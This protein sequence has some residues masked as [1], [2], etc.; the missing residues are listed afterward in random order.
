MVN[1]FGIT[2]PIYWHPDEAGKALQLQQGQYNF[3]HPQLL[4][5]LASLSDAIVPGDSMRHQVLAGRTVSVAAASV[6][7]GTFAVIIARKFGSLWLGAS[8]AV[9]VAATPS[10]FI[11][12]H[13]FKEDAV[14]LMGIAVT[15]LAMQLVDEIP[16]RRRVVALGIALG[17]ACSA[18]YVGVAM[19]IPVAWLLLSRRVAGLDL[20]LCLLFAV[21]VFL[22]V[23]NPTIF[24]PSSLR[25]GFM[26]ELSHVTESHGG[27]AWGPLS[28]RTLLHFW[29]GV[30]IPIFIVLLAGLIVHFG[31]L[32]VFDAIILVSP[33]MWLA[34]AQMSAVSF[35]RYIMPAAALTSVAAVWAYGMTPPTRSRLKVLMLV[36]LLLGGVLMVRPIT[37]A[38]LA[39]VDNP[40]NRAV[41]WI[42]QN[43][44]SDSVI[45]TEFFSGLPTRER[46][47]TDSSVDLLPQKVVQRT[48][49]LSGEGSLDRLR[50]DGVTH[51]VVS[52]SHFDRFYDRYAAYSDLAL[53]QKKFYDEIFSTL[54]PIHEESKYSE[55]D[56]VLSSRVLVYDIR[57]PDNKLIARDAN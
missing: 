37:N 33:F 29:Q 53:T 32:R 31:K 56:I 36:G 5:R 30:S 52:S 47:E 22:A 44:S 54:T 16:S 8:V 23:N 26:S 18:K 48:F 43:L 11:N 38:A 28:P 14:L 57:L 24:G 3:F 17:V 12:A 49:H 42:R 41:A 39:F 19:I 21:L 25:T 27:I 10:V 2:F 20:G 46:V 15:M 51:I 34:I 13:F 50:Q 4:L 35:P 55:T 7:I 45:A 1:L 9:L 6:A 40:R